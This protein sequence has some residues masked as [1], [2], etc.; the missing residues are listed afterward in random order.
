VFGTFTNCF[1]FSGKGSWS[2]ADKVTTKL[3]I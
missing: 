2:K 1:T 3:L